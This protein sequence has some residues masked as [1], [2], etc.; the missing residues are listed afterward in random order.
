MLFIIAILKVGKLWVI[1]LMD[2][3]RW[4][5]SLG[6]S[7]FLQLCY[8]LSYFKGPLF[9]LKIVSIGTWS[10]R[11]SYCSAAYTKM[12]W[13][14]R[15]SSAQ[16]KSMVESRC[17]LVVAY[18]VIVPH[19]SSWFRFS[20]P[21]ISTSWSPRLFLQSCASQVWWCALK[22]P[23]IRSCPGGGESWICRWVHWATV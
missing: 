16:T 6:I 13:D 11:W 17:P 20:L 14:W 8:E 23:T 2:S 7:I 22:S 5:I 1:L 12:S 18:L 9:Q 21:V 4:E 10:E 3:F 19:G 15:V